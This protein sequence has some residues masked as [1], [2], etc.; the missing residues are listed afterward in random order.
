MQPAT[1]ARKLVGMTIRRARQARGWT[2]EQAA[3]KAE[4]AQKTWARV[5]NGEG[6]RAASLTSIAEVFGLPSDALLI[7]LSRDNGYAELAEQLAV[8]VPPPASHYVSLPPEGDENW[9]GPDRAIATAT[10]RV[11]DGAEYIEGLSAFVRA[12]PLVGL[13]DTMLMRLMDSSEAGTITPE[14]EVLLKGLFDYKSAALAAK[15]GRRAT[16]E[17]PADDSA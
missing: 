8:A 15:S 1:D 2:A 11:R 3:E 13:V 5:E 17:A 9:F 16:D 14:E 12:A 4:I 7:A 6:V 10:V